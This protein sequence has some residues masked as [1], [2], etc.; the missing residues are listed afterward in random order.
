MSRQFEIDFFADSRSKTDLSMGT[1]LFSTQD[2]ITV[3][4]TAKLERNSN[5]SV[6]ISADVSDDRNDLFAGE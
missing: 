1:D 5:Q 4:K 3:G 2:E 6:S